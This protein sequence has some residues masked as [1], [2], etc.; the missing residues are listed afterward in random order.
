[1]PVN[2]HRLRDQLLGLDNCPH[3]GVAH[4][5][6]VKVWGQSHANERTDGGQRVFWGVYRCTACGG[7]LTAKCSPDT[8]SPPKVER[9]FPEIWDPSDTI[10]DKARNYL[11]Q[12][13]RTVSSPDASVVMAASSIDAMLKQQGLAKGSLYD[14]IETAVE[15]GLIT[16]SMAEW[17]HRVRLDANNPRHADENSPHMSKEDAERALEFAR[18]FAEILYVLPGRMPKEEAT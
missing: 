3:C 13:A 7:L 5:L 9:V 18:A 4:P 17:V 16:K 8:V 11:L 15:Q 10:P 12:A 6:C 14:R 2:E 1:M